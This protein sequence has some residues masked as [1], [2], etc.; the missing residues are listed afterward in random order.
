MS[1]KTYD[2][3]ALK[4]DP[5]AKEIH[6]T[7]L[8]K[9]I[10]SF[11][12]IN[13]ITIHGGAIVQNS[14]HA[15]RDIKIRAGAFIHGYIYSS[16]NLTIEAG[17]HKPSNQTTLIIGDINVDGRLI[18][19]SS[20]HPS[21][22]IVLGSIIASEVEIKSRIF[23]RGDLIVTESLIAD[24]QKGSFIGGRI[25]IGINE[26]KIGEG[27]IN[28]IGA[29][30]ILCHGNLTIGPKLSLVDPLIV[31]TAGK[32][33]FVRSKK[34]Q[35]ELSIRLINQTCLKCTLIDQSRE[36]PFLCSKY[37]DSSCTIYD[38]IGKMDIFETGN[39]KQPRTT[40]T[41]YWRAGYHQLLNNYIV[42]KFYRN[43]MR[44]DDDIDIEARIVNG[45]TGEEQWFSLIQELTDID[46][47]PESITKFLVEKIQ[48]SRLEDDV[49]VNKV[50]YMMQDLVKK[51][52]NQQLERKEIKEELIGR[53]I[54]SLQRF[55]N[56]LF[57][58]ENCV[59]LFFGNSN[60]KCPRCGSGTKNQA[61][62]RGDMSKVMD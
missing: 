2:D 52:L 60:T 30:A 59:T 46:Y 40:L 8:Y 21:P 49:N 1:Q 18:F 47:S 36:S 48:G 43:V 25:K 54:V 20:D 44:R 32:L 58:C 14:I 34:D 5:V 11:S 22:I 62:S 41:L 33:E 12:T 9:G 37:Q 13:K 28:N 45:A 56:V 55:D 50:I 6:I 31:N 26:N 42:H 3:P 17:I 24:N 38:D 4:Y 7:E 57:V 10:Q 27:K 61:T 39:N 29:T 15:W 35:A 19:E 16:K 23:V 51:G 53:S